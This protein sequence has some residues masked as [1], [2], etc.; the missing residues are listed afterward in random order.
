MTE[1]GFA[2]GGADCNGQHASLPALGRKENIL[3]MAQAPKYTSV[4]NGA[5]PASVV[6]TKMAALGACCDWCSSLLT[7]LV[8]LEI[9]LS[10][11]WASKTTRSVNCA[12]TV[13]LVELMYVGFVG[14]RGKVDYGV[15]ST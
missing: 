5:W 13:R 11:G 9:A 8:R 10:I 15:V 14:K 12:L 3:P 2:C 1:P 4:I 7:G 6:L